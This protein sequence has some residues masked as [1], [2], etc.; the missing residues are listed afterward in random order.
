MGELSR[1]GWVCELSK[2]G[3][4]LVCPGRVGLVGEGPPGGPWWEEPHPGW[5]LIGGLDVFYNGHDQGRENAR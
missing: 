3:D 4:L 2:R 1:W 5:V